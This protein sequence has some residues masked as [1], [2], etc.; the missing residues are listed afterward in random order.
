MNSYAIHT[1]FIKTKRTKP[2]GRVQWYLNTNVSQ[3][4]FEEV[5]NYC[6]Q[7]NVSKSKLIKTLLINYLA[8]IEARQA[9]DNK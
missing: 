8:D 5:E 4:L 6:S 3:N 9:N 7:N 1:Q 2:I